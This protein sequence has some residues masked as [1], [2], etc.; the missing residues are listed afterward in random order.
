MTDKPPIRLNKMQILIMRS[1]NKQMPQ[2]KITR[3]SDA[4]WI[5]V[6][7]AIRK[8]LKGISG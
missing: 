4:S 3:C 2:L 6:S 8:L 7:N 5:Y 1:Q